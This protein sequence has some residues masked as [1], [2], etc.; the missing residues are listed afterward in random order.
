MGA[1]AAEAAPRLLAKG[2]NLR[3][4]LPVA[5]LIDVDEGGSYDTYTSQLASRWLGGYYCLSYAQLLSFPLSKE[6]AQRLRRVSH[7]QSIN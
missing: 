3:F 6:F 1:E 7:K 4:L 5:L 2:V